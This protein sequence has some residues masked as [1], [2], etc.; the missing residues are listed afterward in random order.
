MINKIFKPNSFF[1][2]ELW[3]LIPKDRAMLVLFSTGCLMPAMVSGMYLCLFIYASKIKVRNNCYF[4][5]G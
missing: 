1:P 2:T 5:S 4:Q 3:A